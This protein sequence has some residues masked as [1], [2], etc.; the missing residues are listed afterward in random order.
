MGELGVAGLA[1][2]CQHAP[3]ASPPR[4]GGA[5]AARRWAGQAGVLAGYLAAGV[6]LTWPLAARVPGWLP[7]DRDVSSYVWGLWWVAHQAVHLASPWHTGLLGAPA[8]TPLAFDTLMPLPGLVLAPV[9]LA[10]GPAVS[11]SVLVLALPGLLCWVMYR[12][13]RLWPAS[14]WGA[15][16]AGGFFGLS[17]MLAWQDWYHANI[18]AGELF[19][20]LALAAAVRLA[21]AP[22]PRRAAVLGLVLGAAALVN[23]ESAILAVILA[24]LTLLPWLARRSSFTIMTLR[25]LALTALTALAVA[26][27]QIIAMAAQAGTGGLVGTPHV[28]ARSYRGFGIGV[29][30][31]F[32]PSPSLRRLGLDGLAAVYR[33]RPDFEGVATF[34]V[35]LS[36]AAMAGLAVSWRRR[37]ARL[38]A[39]LWAAAAA[40]SLG[41]ALRAGGRVFTPL[42]L[43][44]H[45]VRLSSLL[46]FTWLVQVP[47]LGAFREADRFALLGLVPA[48]LLAGAAVAWLAARARP[49]VAVLAVLALAEAGWAGGGHFW[50]SMPA[51]IPAVDRPIAADHSG[52]IVVDVPF[53]LWGG[54]PAHFGGPIAPG[55][56]ILAAADGHP[57]AESYSSWIPRQLVTR[58]WAHPFL[59]R[60]AAA[61][62]GWPSSRAQLAAARADATRI[63]VGWAVL[64]RHPPAVLRYLRGLGF[65]FCCRAGRVWLYRLPGRMVATVRGHY[66]GH[67]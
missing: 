24:A 39:L 38:L 2:T 63:R 56:L 11:Y 49:A 61:Q 15:L 26:S 13:A 44:Q 64:W 55:A 33:Y 46:P 12:A 32:A 43:H 41:A 65:R 3:A 35:V 14:Q 30:T 47:G 67:K 48:A 31:L 58:L 29:P 27:P 17:A 50:R 36:V 57:R 28:I 45:G 42:P 16:A 51:A 6:I 62:H 21:R 19:L 60:L 54:I 22:G 23:Q 25:P 53:G 4:P 18:A 40:L 7:A 66:R 1:G 52:S 9:T 34:G 37:S 59:A 20:P 8:G 5:A 10:F